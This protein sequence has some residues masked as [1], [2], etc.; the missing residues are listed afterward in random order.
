MDSGESDPIIPW[1]FDVGDCTTQLYEII[2]GLFFYRRIGLQIP[3]RSN[4]M[5]K[6]MGT[7]CIIYLTW[8]SVDFF[9]G[10]HVGKYTIVPVDMG[11]GLGGGFKHY[12]EFSPRTVGK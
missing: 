8:H 3:V 9:M 5:M 11:D 1:L 10:F 12:L 2:L 4:P 7:V 6:S